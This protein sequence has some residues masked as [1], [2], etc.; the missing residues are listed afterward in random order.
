MPATLATELTW[1]LF[2]F[3]HVHSHCVDRMQANDT[4]PE[5]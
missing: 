2:G 5:Q 3:F 4:A 1:A